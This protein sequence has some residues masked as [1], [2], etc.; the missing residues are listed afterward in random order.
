MLEVISSVSLYQKYCV[1][2]ER[3][4]SDNNAEEVAPTVI[5]DVSSFAKDGH[6]AQGRVAY[7]KRKRK[8]QPDW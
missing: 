3:S 5:L 4:H 6:S 1:S 2:E 8:N 7:F